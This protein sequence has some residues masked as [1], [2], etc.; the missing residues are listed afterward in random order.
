MVDMELCDPVL[1]HIFSYL[2]VSDL[3]TVGQVSRS[4]R[5]LSSVAKRRVNALS[6]ASLEIVKDHNVEKMLNTDRDVHYIKHWKIIEDEIMKNTS[7]IQEN[8]YEY[9]E[10]I[11]EMF[12]RIETLEISFVNNRIL[13]LID[14]HYGNQLKMFGYHEINDEKDIFNDVSENFGEKIEILV[15]SYSVKESTLISFLRKTENLKKLMII[16]ANQDVWEQEVFSGEYVFYLP[17]SLSELILSNTAC[18]R[19]SFNFLAERILKKADENAD[20]CRSSQLNSLH[21][22]TLDYRGFINTSIMKS[23]C[24]INSLRNLTL[25]FRSQEKHLQEEMFDLLGHLQNLEIL[26]LFIDDDFYCDFL[27]CLKKLK[28]F[29]LF[30][31]KSL[32]AFDG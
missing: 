6:M 32:E 8:V 3:I 22:S 9:I 5:A 20:S 28:Q 31:S 29:Y 10:L 14:A 30:G 26:C 19:D 27:R 12:P 2:P 15:N 16:Y 13:K 1:L 18:L 23:I 11:F 7:Q 17:I 25:D 4:W 24:S 21:L